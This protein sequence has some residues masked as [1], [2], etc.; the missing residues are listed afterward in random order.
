M[1]LWEAGAVNDVAAAAP[2]FLLFAAG[3][4]ATSSATLLASLML[5]SVAMVVVR[6]GESCIR[7]TRLGDAI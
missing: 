7:P 4:I 1:L 2:I 6:F 3:A 5:E